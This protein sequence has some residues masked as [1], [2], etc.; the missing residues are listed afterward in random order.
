MSRPLRLEFPGSVHHVTSRGNERRN[1]FADDADCEVFLDLLGVCTGRFE[2]IVTAYALMSNHFHLVVQLTD[3]TL[4]R[5]LQWL[6]SQY[7]Q[8]FNRRHGRV[9]HLLQG[10]P[11]IRLVDHETYA[12][13]VLRYVVLNPVRA[14]IVP[15]P[16]DYEWT[17]HRTVLGLAD[18]P[19]WL[20][21]DD[22]LVQ[23]APERDTARALYREFVDC[24]IG[25]TQSPW[26][27]LVGQIYLGSEE[28][29]AGVRERVNLQPRSAEHPR[30]QRFVPA[31]TMADIIRRVAEA[32]S[33]DE[34]QIRFGRGG[35]TRTVAAW[36]AWHEGQLTA[37]EI[38]AGLRL[39]CAGHVSRL[40][41]RCEREL[42]SRPELR[43][44]VEASSLRFVEKSQGKT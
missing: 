21:V 8:H 41:A 29:V 10:R 18:A 32:F 27:N 3:E 34:N 9:G 5:G 12:L 20:A 39:R 23:F 2:W 14:H 33:I 24:A 26:S 19:K 42:E 25:S 28:W 7:S 22:V 38:A 43:S 4:S 13:E 37:S 11:D 31:A 30:A 15:R 35:L 40:V 1:I 16:E 17:S 36:I 6:N 44:K